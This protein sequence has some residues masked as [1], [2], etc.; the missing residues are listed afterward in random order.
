MNSCNNGYATLAAISPPAVDESQP[1]IP[2]QFPPEPEPAALAVVQSGPLQVLGS[3]LNNARI[4]AARIAEKVGGP[5]V[6]RLAR[7]ISL[8][9]AHKTDLSSFLTDDARGRELPS[10]LCSL[11]VHMAD[12]QAQILQEVAL[13]ASDLERLK[14]IVATQECGVTPSAAIEN[15][16]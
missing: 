10:Y 11:A 13:L 2:R 6:A 7:A 3:V 4:S 15:A 16:A 8:M 9:Q 14:E 12:E 1:I 5:K